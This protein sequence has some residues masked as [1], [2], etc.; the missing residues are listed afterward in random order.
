MVFL[1]VQFALLTR[2]AVHG[3]QYSFQVFQFPQAPITTA[4]GINN[5]GQVVGIVQGLGQNA[6][7][8]KD[9][10]VFSLINVPGA[11]PLNGTIASGINDS[12]QIVG[13][14]VTEVPDIHG[15]G[16][17]QSA[18]TIT[19][20]DFPGSS[21]TDAS[22]INN[23]GQIVGR[24]FPAQGNQIGRGFLKDGSSFTSLDVPGVQAPAG[25]SPYGINDHGQIVGEFLDATGF[26]SFLLQSN[27]F[28]VINVPGSDNT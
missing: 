7:F 22:G 27:I 26:H 12:A 13:L 8:L 14:Y 23:S 1:F 24:F 17:L 28:S 9:G 10:N 18:G 4:T 25:T 16:F 20:I 21:Y 6:G 15:H 19:T 11:G 3:Q 5:H 2:S